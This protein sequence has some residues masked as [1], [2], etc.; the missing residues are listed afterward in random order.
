MCVCVCTRFSSA[1]S[2]F[3]PNPESSSSSSSSGE[4]KH[5]KGGVNHV[6]VKLSQEVGPAA[7]DRRSAQRL[8]GPRVRSYV[9][10][11]LGSGVEINP[12]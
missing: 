2:L 6:P 1:L 4:G 12:R 5:H 8:L 3:L 10:H 9:C 7:G 11:Q